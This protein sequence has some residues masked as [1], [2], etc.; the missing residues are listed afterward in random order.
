[1]RTLPP[2]LAAHLRSGTT[3]L[4]RCWR[5]ERTD[6]RVQG[7]TDHD[8][9]IM[10][11]GVTYSAMD[12]AEATADAVKTGLAVGGFEIGGALSSTGLD[13][14]DLADGRYD[15]ASVELWLV[16]WADVSERVL[17]RR[18]TLGEV[19]RADD[20]FQAEVRG[21]TQALETVRGRIYAP[22]CDAD[23]GDRR[24]KVDVAGLT[25]TVTLAAVKGAVVTVSGLTGEPAGWFSG[26]TMRVASGSEAGTAL[27]VGGHMKAG[28]THV[29][30]VRPTVCGLA[31]GDTATLGPGCDKRFE[32]CRQKFA[33]TTNF[34]G[35][36]HLPGN[37]KVLGYARRRA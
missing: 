6:G 33:N 21:P 37:D 20:A 30:T 11:G 3:T 16:N 23:L 25:V 36:P 5:F 32:T 17:L 19:T 15:G 1:M 10:F 8:Q 26:G 35:F 13:P 4:A 18:G 14:D 24:C 29:L 27:S 7:F 34:R 9:P 22:T 2:G 12:G 28:D 31:A